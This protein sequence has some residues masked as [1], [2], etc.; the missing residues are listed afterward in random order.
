MKE[1]RLG[2][3]SYVEILLKLFCDVECHKYGD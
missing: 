3:K 2:L 1:T